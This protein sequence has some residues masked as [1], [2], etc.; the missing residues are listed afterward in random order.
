MYIHMTRL[1]YHAIT[2]NCFLRGIDELVFPQTRI[3]KEIYSMVVWVFKLSFLLVLC[4]LKH[5]K[6]NFSHGS[7]DISKK[8]TNIWRCSLENQVKWPIFLN[9]YFWYRF[10]YIVFYLQGNWQNID[11]SFPW[12]HRNLISLIMHLSYWHQIIFRD[13]RR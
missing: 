6:Y 10:E 8:E 3:P 5:E 12:Y 11:W 4:K 9:H 2:L 1:S 13:C 7:N